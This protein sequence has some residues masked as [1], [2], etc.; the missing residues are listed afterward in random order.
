MAVDAA[1]VQASPIG[2]ND[3]AR[4]L[5][6]GPYAVEVLANVMVAMRDGVQ[7]AV[8]LYLP[9]A[10]AGAVGMRWPCLL[11]RTP[12]DKSA[13]AQSDLVAGDPRPLSKPQIARWFASHGFVMAMQDCRGRYR[14]QGVFTKYTNEAEDGH[15]TLA[16]L[17]AQP[18]SD[19]RV[20]TQG[21]SYCAHVQTALGSLAPPALAAQFVDSGGFSNAYQGGIRQGGAFELK[22]ATWAYKHALLSPLTQADP[23]RKAALQAQDIRAW[24]RRMPWAR[25]DSPVS[26]APEYEDYLFEQWEQGDF[27][28]YWQQ[29]ELCGERHYDGYGDVPM[30]HMSSWYDPYV[31]TATENYIGLSQRKRGPVHLIM[32]PWVHGR[33]SQTYSGDVD[34]G[35]QST[36]DAAFGG[37]FYQLRRAW[38]DYVLGRSHDNPFQRG[39]VSIFVMGGG[40]GGRDAAGRLQHGG[41][42]V[43]AQDWPLPGTRTQA[44]HLHA[45]GRLDPSASSEPDAS[46]AYTYDPAQPVPTIGGTI[47]SADEIMLPGAFDQRDDARFFGC[48]GSGR[49]IGERDDVLS[50]R[51]APLAQVVE[52]AG[53]IRASLFVSSDCA[54]TDI[55][56]KLIDE[57]PPSA[58]YPHGFAMNL[59]DGIL[60]LRY[61]ESWEQPQRLVPGQVVKIEVE[62]FAT[63]N[64]FAR[65]HRI[66]LD[67]SSSN[68]PHFDLNPNT[69]AAPGRW[70]QAKVARN[71]VHMDA[72]HPSHLLLP[73]LPL[74]DDDA[75]G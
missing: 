37:S 20:I 62:A 26:A 50:F 21:L 36:L 11:E 34:F 13:I 1:I 9:V 10:S 15:D 51:S 32:G 63:A 46:R 73:V 31:R 6:D 49:D 44:W 28:P 30:V 40:S 24:F 29:V 52:I 43:H 3:A 45:D 33:R 2:E 60:R 22:Q 41:R 70:Q 7:L 56:I 57:Y 59:S 53:V 19:G 55:T 69:D 74:C 39:P 4:A 54:D 75:Q 48:S 72:D 23:A 66:R 64:R 61:R 12:Y 71:R 35:P 14:S 42:W 8:D 17:A 67:V 16:W 65:G 25:G 5:Q 18:W 47:T 58:E 68:Y 38:Y 27:G